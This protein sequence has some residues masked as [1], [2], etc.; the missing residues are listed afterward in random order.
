MVAVLIVP[1]MV[2]STA[3]SGA[4]DPVISYAV[5]GTYQITGI[6]FED[7]KVLSY[8]ET[9]ESEARIFI[10][11]NGYAKTPNKAAELA[12]HLYRGGNPHVSIT[13]NVDNS[14]SAIYRGGA[15]KTYYEYRMQDGYLVARNTSEDTFVSGN[16]IYSSGAFYTLVQGSFALG[17]GTFLILERELEEQYKLII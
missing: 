11:E 9:T 15:S 13:I 7:G 17:L 1:C 12:W 6:L 5:V 4:D 16:L 3:C 10:L 8:S 14:Y 2:L